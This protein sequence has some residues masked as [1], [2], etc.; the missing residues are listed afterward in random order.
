MAT[1]GITI[2]K[3]FI[4]GLKEAYDKAVKE[5]KEQFVYDTHDFVTSYAKYFLEFYAPKFN[6]KI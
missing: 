4:V 1:K 5:G 3:A 2:N 6:V